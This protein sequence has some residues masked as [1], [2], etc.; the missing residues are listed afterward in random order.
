MQLNYTKLGD[1]QHKFKS[2]H[3]GGTNGKG[4]TSHMLA[5]V[6]QTVGYK[7]TKQP[8]RPIRRTSGSVSVVMG[9]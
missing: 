8:P 4:S 2:V 7:T 9:R 6:L 1:P 5:A 3:I